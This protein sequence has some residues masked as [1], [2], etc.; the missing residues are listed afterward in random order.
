MKWYPLDVHH[1]SE[2]KQYH[3]LKIQFENNNKEIIIRSA[4]Y[5]PELSETR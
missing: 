5:V 3:Q 2:Y 1:I 4:I